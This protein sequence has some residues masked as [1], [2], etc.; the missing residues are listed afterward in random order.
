MLGEEYILQNFEC[1][2][3]K[4]NDLFICLGSLIDSFYYMTPLS[5][6]P[7]NDNYHISRKR[8]EPSIILH[9]C[10]GHINLNRIQR[11][12]KCRILPSLILKELI[13]SEFYIKG[14]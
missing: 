6:L 14:K 4:M 2:F 12:V 9:L 8:K 7:N 10:L 5:V 11:L 3:I 1:L 13:A